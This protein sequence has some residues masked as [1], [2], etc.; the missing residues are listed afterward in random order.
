MKKPQTVVADGVL[1]SKSDSP[2]LEERPQKSKTP[3]ELARRDAAAMVHILNRMRGG[4]HS[5][6]HIYES[7]KT[8]HGEPFDQ[9]FRDELAQN[10]GHN[11]NE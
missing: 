9:Y 8:L 7:L 2:N 5:Y 3:D 1:K 11:D 6:E 4:M 10:R